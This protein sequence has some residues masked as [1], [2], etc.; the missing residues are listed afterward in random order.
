M[1]NISYS[2]MQSRNSL[3]GSNGGTLSEL[4]MLDGQG[5][6]SFGA[7]LPQQLAD[8][9]GK[10][11]QEKFAELML[12]LEMYAK[13]KVLAG[14]VMTKDGQLEN[15]TV[16]SVST[17]TKCINGEH[18]S[19]IGA[20]VNDCHAE[21][22]S[23][24]CLM[25][26]LYGQLRL[27]F[28]EATKATSIFEEC[29]DRPEYY[30][31]KAGIEF[32]LYINTAPCGD[33]RI[34]SPHDAE[35]NNVDKHPNRKARGQLRTKIESG[36]GTIPAKNNS[37]LQTWDGVIQGQRLLTMSC[38]DKIAKWNVM[39]IQGS[40]LASLVK[41]IYL[42][43]IVLGS[44]LHPAHMYRAVCGRIEAAVAGDLPSPYYLNRP[45][46]ALVTSAEHRNQLKAPNFSVNWSYGD[47]EVEVINSVTGKTVQAQVSRI[48]KSMFIVRYMSAVQHLKTDP[49]KLESEYGEL[50]AAV[51]EYQVS[52]RGW[53]RVGGWILQ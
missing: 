47:A 2:P 41:P 51:K 29:P 13:R 33:A 5:G 7:E 11:V 38:S 3:G 15:A 24:R 17:G 14:I 1:R 52:G 42:A 19:I 46:L 30:Q 43:S 22:I 10:L 37:G 16:I 35:N 31:L 4:A 18:I 50:K 25:V 32:H 45:K 28:S 40:L 21:I 23:R 39:G 20:V 9:I 53:I 49:P 36:E 12:G 8:G 48:S 6:E 44:L 26:F 34:F 27:L